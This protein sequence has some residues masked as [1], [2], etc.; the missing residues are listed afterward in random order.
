MAGV[1]VPKTN[2]A[3]PVDPALF[4][5]DPF[6]FNGRVL[7]TDEDGGTSGDDPYNIDRDLGQGSGVVAGNPKTFFTAAHLLYDKDAGW[8]GPPSWT[9][10]GA[11][12]PSDSTGARGYFRWADY[13][14]NVTA[15]LAGQNASPAFSRDIA[16][17]WGLTPF[18]DGAPAEIDFSGSKKLLA[19]KNLSM[20]TGYP[21]T[22]DYEGV[23]STGTLYATTPEF[24]LFTV[25]TGKFLNATYVSSGPGNSGGPIWI[26]DSGGNW[27]ASGVLVFN[28]PSEAGVYAFTPAVKSLM[29]AAAPLVGDV[30]KSVKNGPASITTSSA[31]FVLPKP[32]KIPDGLHRWTKV[33]FS[34]N[35]FEENTEYDGAFV[36][37]TITTAHR[38]DLMVALMAPSGAMVMIHDGAGGSEDDLVID[39]FSAGQAF[40][41][42]EWEGDAGH[43]NG[44]WTL[45]VQ[46]RLKGDPSVI[47][48]FELEVRSKDTMDGG[49]EEP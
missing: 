22:L 17:A 27:A 33:P 4:N 12:G 21:E 11:T 42:E 10:V 9:G 29:K 26:Q 7:T 46:D 30:R 25:D 49:S 48:R 16:L 39:N 6:V 2:S 41:D 38:G 43:P 5:E 13:S 8:T 19:Q 28:R 15:N 14:T 1:P 24:S 35:R 32:K 31:R 44:I 20:I 37:L 23:S 34:I 45:L 47:T 40:E 36:D 3:T 18:I